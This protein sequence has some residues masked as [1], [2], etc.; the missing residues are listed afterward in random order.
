MAKDKITDKQRLNWLEKQG[1]GRLWIARQSW[2]GRG[3]R[4]HNCEKKEFNKKFTGKTAREA[5]DKAMK[6]NDENN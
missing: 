2:T 3:F 6:E 5:I 4:V 1:A